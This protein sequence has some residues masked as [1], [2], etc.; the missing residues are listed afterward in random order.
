MHFSSRVH[1]NPL[2][3][4]MYRMQCSVKARVRASVG[5]MLYAMYV[6]NIFSFFFLSFLL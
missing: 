4:S 6:L 5:S 2:G 1:K 3:E